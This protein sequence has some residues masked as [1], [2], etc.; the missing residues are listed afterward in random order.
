MAN[1]LLNIEKGIEIGAADALKWLGHAQTAIS[2]APAVVAGLA[3]LISTL[4][5]PLTDVSGVI[6]NPLNIPLDIQ[7]AND[8]KAVWPQIK[9][10]LGTLGVKF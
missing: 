5:K 10:F 9:T 1:I 6:A 2:A 3:T 8:L 4:D 7:T